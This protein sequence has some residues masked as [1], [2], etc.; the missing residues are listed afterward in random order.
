MSAVKII[1]SQRNTFYCNYTIDVNNTLNEEVG[2]ALAFPASALNIKANNA[3]ISVEKFAMFNLELQRI[4]PLL[5]I[6]QLRT[7]IPST[8]CTD[9]GDN[10]SYFENIVFDNIDFF[11][12]TKVDRHFNSYKNNNP[13]YKVM[14]A[15]PLSGRHTLQLLEFSSA[16]ATSPIA[17]TTKNLKFIT[18][19]LKVELIEEDIF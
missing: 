16:G 14:C 8:S 4:D 6:I 10:R 5:S 11:E 9:Q 12:I 3:F 7:T 19:T 1:Q 18:L 15:N 2:L 13:A 17:T